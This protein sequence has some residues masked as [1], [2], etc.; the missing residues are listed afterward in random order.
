MTMIDEL[1]KQ[2]SEGKDQSKMLMQ[3]VLREAFQK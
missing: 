3:S 2:V 1:E